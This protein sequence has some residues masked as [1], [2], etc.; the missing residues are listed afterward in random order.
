VFEHLY[1]IYENDRYVILVALQSDGVLINIDFVELKVVGAPC[2]ED[3][4]FG[5]LTQVAA[6]PA[7]DDDNSPVHKAVQIED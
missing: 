2:G 6:W 5:L 7:V 3:S 4:S 1:A